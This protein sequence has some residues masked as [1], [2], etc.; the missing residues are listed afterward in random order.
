MEA[1]RI[2]EMLTRL[3]CSKIKQGYNAWVNAT[4]PL[5]QWRHPS[6]HDENPSFGVSVESGGASKYKCHSCGTSGEL[7]YLI[8]SIA[9]YSKKDMSELL[10]FVQ[11]HNQP[12]EAELK[13]RSEKSKDYWREKTTVAGITIQPTAMEKR[14][15]IPELVVLPES[16]LDALRVISPEV[17]HEL[18]V[19]RRL[20][21]ETVKR[22]ELG[23]HPG[24]GRIA[25]PIRDCQKALVGISGRAFPDGKPKYL[26]SAGF[27]GAFYLYGEDKAVRNTRVH[28]CEGFFDVLYLWQKGYNAVAMQ[29]TNITTFQVE[30][31]KKLF[32]ECA[33]VL[34]GDQPGRVAADKALLAVGA[35]MHTTKVNVPM[36]MDPKDLS[37]EEL[38]DLLGPPQF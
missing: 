8:F 3:G 1:A 25:I 30:K 29:G 11:R 6:G 19:V 4:C 13:A 16:A 35:A 32:S 34:D 22:W 21:E 10:Q 18:T 24:A 9:R 33:I 37:D 31:L 27:R 23:W 14:V 15:P 7:T 36:G 20:N 5:A 12:S 2:E 26:H 38:I 17:M 28:L